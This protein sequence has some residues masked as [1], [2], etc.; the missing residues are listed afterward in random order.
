MAASDEPRWWQAVAAALAGV[1]VAGPDEGSQPAEAAPLADWLRRRGVDGDAVRAER[2]RRLVL[3]ETWPT[4]VHQLPAD[5]RLQEVSAAQWASLL[6]DVRAL[7][8]VS[9]QVAQVRRPSVALSPADR[10]LIADRPPH[11]GG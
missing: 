7:L 9:G 10:R 11:H 4:P 5:L 6:A 3:R 2:T 8:G 1:E